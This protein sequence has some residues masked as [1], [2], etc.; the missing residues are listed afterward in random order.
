VLLSDDAIGFGDTWIWLAIVIYVIAPGIS[1]A[2]LFPR[3]DQME[4]LMTELSSGPPPGGAGG[5]PPQVALLEVLG[6]QIGIFS[7]ILHLALV[8]II[9][10]MVTTPA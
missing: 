7:S 8:L 6:K 2:R 9:I 3:L 4:S 10:L 1:H 5:P